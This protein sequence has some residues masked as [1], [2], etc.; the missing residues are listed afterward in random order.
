MEFRYSVCLDGSEDIVKMIADEHDLSC[1]FD[2]QVR[3]TADL[4]DGSCVTEIWH[5]MDYLAGAPFDV[6]LS[7]DGWHMRACSNPY[8]RPYEH[9]TCNH[10]FFDKIRSLS[11][12]IDYVSAYLKESNVPRALLNKLS[13]AH[14]L[15]FEVYK[16]IREL[17]P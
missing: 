8:S 1:F 12:E 15:L 4:V 6:E 16:D 5:C 17:W 3:T 14:E 2:E 10:L 11:M 7:V 13:Q 9:K